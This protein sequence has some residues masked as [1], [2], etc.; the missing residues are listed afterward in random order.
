MTIDCRAG[1]TIRHLP[2]LEER[3]VL[4]IDRGMVATLGVSDLAD[5][6]DCEVIERCSDAKHEALL[7]K[8]ATP[9]PCSRLAAARAKR[10]LWLTKYERGLAA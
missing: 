7:A 10:A 3:T 1:D 5:A 8:L 4:Y 2:T 9:W 6:E